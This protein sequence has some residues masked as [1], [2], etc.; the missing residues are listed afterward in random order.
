MRSITS[1]SCKKVHSLVCTVLA[2]VY[3]MAL[4]LACTAPK[5]LPPTAAANS[6]NCN[7]QKEYNYR[8]ADMPVPYHTLQIDTLLTRRFSTQALQAAHAIGLLGT[9][10]AFVALQQQQAAHPASQQYIQLLQYMQRIQQRIQVASLE[11]AA[12]AGEMDC[13]EERAD[14]IAVYLNNLQDNTANRLTVGAIVAGAAGAVTAGL[15]LLSGNTSNAPELIGIGTGLVE[16]VLG[17]LLLRP[18]K[19]VQFLHPRNALSDIWNGPATSS[20]FPAPVWYYLNYENDT[21]KPL[22]PRRQLIAKWQNF[23]Q[24][25]D[26]KEKK[27]QQ[28]YNLFF[29]K[30]GAYTADQ[31]TNRANMYDQI[32]AQINLMKQD[33]KL[34][35]AELEQ[36]YTPF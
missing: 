25:A 10:K 4:P 23:G 17:A 16:T 24:I 14:Q 20:I 34:L 28:V 21:D 6:S 22:S 32:E 27:K 19:T 12:V 30:G 15:L 2:S 11:I 18:Q 1:L 35:A 9:L 29:G 31:L 33:L 7:H 26:V 13:E 5:T 36:L 3:I 8:A